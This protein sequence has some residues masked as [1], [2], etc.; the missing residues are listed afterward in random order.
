MV[1]DWLTKNGA[2]QQT[3]DICVALMRRCIAVPVGRNFGT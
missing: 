1:A 2:Q 3:P